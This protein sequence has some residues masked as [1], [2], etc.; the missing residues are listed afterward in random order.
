MEFQSVTRFQ[1]GLGLLF[2][3]QTGFSSW[4]ERLILIITTYTRKSS[5]EFSELES[6]FVGATPCLFN[7]PGYRILRWEC[8]KVILITKA[9]QVRGAMVRCHLYHTCPGQSYSGTLVLLSSGATR[10]RIPRCH[11]TCGHRRTAAQA[12]PGA[13]ITAVCSRTVSIRY[14]G[15]VLQCKA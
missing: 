15:T 12:I 5:F 4:R 11:V 14:Y 10:A 9:L 1:H 2:Q 13:R 7:A 8:F 3:P 6:S